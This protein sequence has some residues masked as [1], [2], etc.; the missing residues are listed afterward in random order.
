M[1]AIQRRFYKEGKVGSKKK[2]PNQNTFLFCTMKYL[3]CH[4]INLTV[5]SENKLLSFARLQQ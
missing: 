3:Q 4:L 1:E 2:K 5:T